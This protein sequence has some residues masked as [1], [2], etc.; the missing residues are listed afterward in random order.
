MALT[1]VSG[2]ILDPGINVAGIVTATGFDG[3]FVGGIGDH[4][5]A[6]IV[7]ATALDI[8]GNA[9]IS[10]S[11]TVGSGGLDLNGSGDISGDL[12]IH[13]NLT[14]NGDFTTLNTTLREVELLRVDANSNT[15]A[16]IITQRGSGDLLRLDDGSTRAVTVFCGI[17]TD[18]ANKIDGGQ[19]SIGS[20][21]MWRTD[22][23]A[24]VY[25]KSPD[26]NFSRF[27]DQFMVAGSETNGAANTGAGIQFFGHDGVQERGMAYIRGLKENGTSGNQASYLAFATRVNGGTLEERVRISS[28]GNVGIGSTIPNEKLDVVGVTS[29]TGDVFFK[30]AITSP[31]P[32]D[33]FWDYSAAEL[34]FNDNAII[35]LGTN[36]DAFLSHDGSATR[37]QDNYGH[38][39]IGGNLIQI[40]SG[41]LSEEYIR[42]DNTSK[43]VKLYHNS[44]QRL[45]TDAYGIN[46][47]KIGGAPQVAIAQTTT[48]AYSINGS[49]SFVNGNNTTA[50]IQGRTGAASTTGDIIFLCNTVGD[51]T[52]SVLEDG[53]VRVPDRGRFVVGSGNDL[54]LY[55]D[56]GGSGSHIQNSGSNLTVRTTGTYLYMHGNNI[57][58]RSQTGNETMLT[59]VVNSAVSLYYDA[60]TYTT[61]KLQ[62]TST[63]AQIDTILTCYGAAGNP[64]RIRLQEG[65]AISEI[66]V[67]RS[68]DTSS[69][70]LFGTEISGTTAT[71]WKIDTAGH[72]IPSA[73][74]TY[75]IGSTSA[76]VGNVY[77]ADSKTIWIGSDQD[78]R[79][80]HDPTHTVSYI[81]NTGPLNIQ[82]DDLRLYNYSTADLYLRATTNSSVQLFYDY[83][84][85]T[86]PK[87]ETSAT[88][89]TVGGEV[90]ATQDYPTIQPTLNFNFAATKKLDPRITYSRTGTASYYDEFGLLK[91]VGDNV[92]RFDHDL[93]TGECKGLLIEEQRT[94]LL[95]NSDQATMSSPNLGGNPQVNTSV[96]NITL[97]TGEQG[98]VR[99]YLANA[100]GGGGR[101]GDYS[102]TNN[103]SYTGSVWVRTVSGTGT[104]IIDI[105]DG[106]SKT[107]NLTTEW[108]RVTTTHSSNNTYR[109]FDIYFATP[110]T[111]YYWGVQIEEGA[112]MTSYIPTYGS[113]KTRGADLV[114][115]TEEEFS[116]FYNPTEG[117]F[118]SEITLPPYF[119]VTAKATV[120]MTLSDSS[121]NNRVTLGSSTGSTAFNADITISGT[122]NRASLGSYTSGSYSIKAAIAYKASDSA[123]CLN[124]AAAV[125]TSPG[126]LPLLTRA[127]IGKDHTDFN[128][129]GGHMKRLMYYSKRLPNNQLRTLTS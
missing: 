70:L 14:A 118:V 41:N 66:K 87:L 30:G 105:N 23:V 35:Y 44:A 10:G 89:I 100:P 110:V 60:S 55:H 12:V 54:S 126:T 91:I 26:L 101:W 18:S 120:M 63:G 92:P 98:T 75:D 39:F 37:L 4:I 53:K 2:G 67:E 129:L 77:V 5:I 31:A 7:T 16:G 83:S 20:T 94:N 82:T 52:L 71:R 19:V 84:T 57:H 42:M 34:R 62:T 64:G 88:G 121:Y 103:T 93:E 73:V 43:E 122:N 79:I 3:P 117:S 74:G 15:V 125:T 106:G 51:E 76:E 69:A 1:K 36:K 27:N 22:T 40:K 90:A 81:Q 58:L 115:I 47:S 32:R 97:P 49:V 99:A 109:F 8:N 38:F 111:I 48:G 113:S 128:L 61:P 68:T 21:F 104:A 33:M 96:E 80:A 50:Q 127:D 56:N 45:N 95:G 72:F 28:E 9:D 6:G 46:V 65:G 17:G 116:E 114:E 108:Q 13:G 123:G 59:A 78:L 25:G 107:I 112:F 119:P 24:Q 11:L 85:Y 29:F 102:G 124:G 86:T